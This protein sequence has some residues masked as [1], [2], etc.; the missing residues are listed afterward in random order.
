MQHA[1]LFE[2]VLL[3]KITTIS[4]LFVFEYYHA[5]ILMENVVLIEEI[6]YTQ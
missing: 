5:R 4:M 3:I 1:V 6:L 2:V